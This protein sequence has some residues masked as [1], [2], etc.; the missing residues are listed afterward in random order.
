MPEELVEE[1]RYYS[2]ASGSF[3]LESL[4]DAY[5]AAGTWPADAVE[6]TDKEWNTYGAGQIPEGQQR[7]ADAQG[8]PVWVAIVRTSEE[9]ESTERAW[10]DRQ[11]LIS[12][13]LVTRHRDEAEA[14]RPTSLQADQY[15]ELQG[16]RMDLRNWPQSENFP[17][18][19]SRPHEPH[20]LAALLP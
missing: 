14:G 16:F 2:A 13:P 15:Q 19:N 18:A 20:W 8:R 17:S 9:N 12:D 7:G 1:I 6:V 4:R 11:L 3:V 5:N 10:R